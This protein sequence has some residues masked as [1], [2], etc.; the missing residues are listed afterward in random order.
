M[1][2]SP[3]SSFSSS[4]GDLAVELQHFRDIPLVVTISLGEGAVPLRELVSLSPGTVIRLNQAAGAD[5]RVHVGDIAI[6]LGEVV[7]IEDTI[8]VRLTQML[9][10]TGEPIA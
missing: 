4:G 7:I 10:P 8:G 3:S 6:G 2:S 9:S 1:S 5:L